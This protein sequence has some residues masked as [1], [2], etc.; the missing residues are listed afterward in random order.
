VVFNQSNGYDIYRRHAVLCIIAAM[1]SVDVMHVFNYS[2]VDIMPAM[3]AM[4]T[5]TLCLQ[6]VLV[7]SYCDKKLL[8]A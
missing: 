4:Q 8:I 5:C 7:T 6:D 2:V 1:M 3:P